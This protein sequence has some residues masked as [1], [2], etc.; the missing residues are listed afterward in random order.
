[1]IDPNDNLQSAK[2]ST[3][4]AKDKFPLFFWGLGLLFS[5]LKVSLIRTQNRNQAANLLVLN[6]EAAGYKIK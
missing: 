1:M 4:W 2:S 3:N 5:V 6:Y